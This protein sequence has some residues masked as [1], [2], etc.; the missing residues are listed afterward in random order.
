MSFPLSECKKWFAEHEE[1]IKKDFFDFLRFQSISADPAYHKQC[2]KAADWLIDYLDKQIGIEARELKGPTI[3]TVFAEKKV[4]N[5]PSLFL[6]HHYDVQPV[7]PL[8]LWKSD[9]FEPRFDG[10]N[11][12]ARGA[13]DNK[14]QCFITLTALKAARSL[15]PHLPLHI[16]LFIEGEEE[17]GGVGTYEILQKNKELLRAD[18]LCVIDFDAKAPGEPAITMG[19]RGLIAA[20]I[21]CVNAACDLH[22]GV[23]GGIARNALQIL[24]EVLAKCYDEKGQVLIPGFYEGIELLSEEEKEKVDFSFDRNKYEEEFGVKA[25]C[26]DDVLSIKENNTLRPTLEINGLWG[27]Y[28][29]A[30]FKTVIP[31]K[32][33]AKLSCRLVLGQDPEYLQTKIRDFI[34]KN[35]PKGCQITIRWLQGAKA[36]RTSFQS[37]ITREVVLSLEEVFMKP[38]SYVLCGASIPIVRDLAEVVGGEVALFGFSLATDNIHAPNEHFFFEHFKKGFLTMLR[39]FWGI[40]QKKAKI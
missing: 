37:D 25:L 9:P 24:T 33:S 13:S 10:E 6:Y 29:G 8:D 12:F 39:L 16:K 32:A 34:E 26:C 1:Q 15:F 17:S 27:G 14:G 2:K 40:A 11:I 30:G 18:T 20:E 3:S 23:H 4:E 7:D 28:T 36:Y 21:E 38:C 31:A 5:A 19:Y 22:S 35:T